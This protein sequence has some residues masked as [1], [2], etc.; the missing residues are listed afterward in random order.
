VVVTRAGEAQACSSSREGR[1]GSRSPSRRSAPSKAS[2]TRSPPRFTRAPPSR[3]ASPAENVATARAEEES[4]RTARPG[5]RGRARRRTK[6]PRHLPLARP[7]AVGVYSAASR[8]AFEAIERRVRGN[9]P[10]AVVAPSGVDP[11]PYLAR[12]H[13]GGPRAAEPLVLVDAPLRASTISSAGTIAAP[14]R[15]PWP[16]G[17]CWSSSTAPPPGRCPAPGRPRPRRA[18]APR[19]SAPEPLEIALAFSATSRPDELVAAGKARSAPRRPPRRRP[20]GPHPHSRASPSA[21]RHPRH[22]HRSAGARGDAGPRHPVASRIAPSRTWSNTPSSGDADSRR[23][24]QRLV[25]RASGDVVRAA[26]VE[27]LKLQ[28]GR[29]RAWLPIRLCRGAFPRDTSIGPHA[30]DAPAAPRRRC[31][32][33]RLLRSAVRAGARSLTRPPRRGPAERRPSRACPP[34]VHPVKV[35]DAYSIYGAVHH[36]H[37]RIHSTEVTAKDISITGYI[38]DSNI[39]P[40]RSAPS[41]RPARRTP[42]TASTSP[43]LP[44]GLAD[45]KGDPRRSRT[46]ASSAGEEF[47]HG[48]E[49]DGEVQGQGVPERAGQ[50]R[51]LGCRRAVSAPAVGAK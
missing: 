30:H 44:S 16:I 41:T 49:R 11:V 43:S 18:A 35:G 7:A 37:S 45:T 19:G 12:A 51:H 1:G 46:S 27:A 38:V 33:A 40:R 5:P 36:L 24:V 4:D 10:I 29:P 22:P 2:P 13:L 32:R 31:F 14:P 23:V 50:G 20:G 47:R 8:M 6:R 26:D 15:S 21:R 9:A 17:A 25:A 28:E 3:G 48:V 42:T 34:A 39:R